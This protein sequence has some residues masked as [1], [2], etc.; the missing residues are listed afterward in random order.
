MHPEEPRLARRHSPVAVR[1]HEGD[2]TVPILMRRS[3]HLALKD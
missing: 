2:A 1:A 3:T